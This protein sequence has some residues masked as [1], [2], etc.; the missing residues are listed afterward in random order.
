MWG[1]VRVWR[2]THCDLPAG[3]RGTLCSWACCSGLAERSSTCS[4]GPAGE[5]EE[6]E[7]GEEE[8][9]HLTSPDIK[10]KNL[11]TLHRGNKWKNVEKTWN[12]R[13]LLSQI[14]IYV[15][16]FCRNC[17]SL[18]RIYVTLPWSDPHAGF[19]SVVQEAKKHHQSIL[20][21]NFFASFWTSRN[22]TQ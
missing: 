11:H 18:P 9:E 3:R 6:K 17:E 21:G 15:G 5:W 7:R 13:P 20:A 12:F 22:R 2:G 14:L 10:S 4:W 16:V 1:T 8:A 19:G